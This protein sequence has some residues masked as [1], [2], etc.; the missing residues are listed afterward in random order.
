MGVQGRMYIQ[1]GRASDRPDSKEAV[2]ADP[3]IRGRQ[4]AAIWTF[5]AVGATVRFSRPFKIPGSPPG[6]FKEFY[7]NH[8]KSFRVF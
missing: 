1:V 2:R 6:Y 8:V 3:S 7:K 4:P 5:R